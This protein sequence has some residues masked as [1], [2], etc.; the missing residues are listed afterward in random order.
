M[1]SFLILILLLAPLQAQPL[2]RVLEREN[3]RVDVLLDWQP[4]QPAPR[5]PDRL[6]LPERP[7]EPPVQPRPEPAETPVS[8]SDFEGWIRAY[9]GG[10]SSAEAR[11]IAS[12]ILSL[13]RRHRVEPELVLALVAAESAF[14]SRAVSPVG[15]RGLGQLMPSTAA[16]LGVS[17]AFDPEQNL[18]GT[19]RYLATQLKRFGNPRLALAAYNAGPGAVQRYG[20][21]PPYQETQQYVGYVLKLYQELNTQK[22]AGKLA[23][24]GV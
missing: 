9:N 5:L 21:V 2:E 15:A 11:L 4:G 20:G 24:E 8:R 16:M 10:V 14:Q 1:R 6:P 17:D 19:V 22:S 23:A 12:T 18:S 7:P 3:Q 13:C